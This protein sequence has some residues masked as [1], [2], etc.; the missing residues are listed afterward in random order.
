[1][2]VN[3]LPRKI[4]CRILFTVCFL[5]FFLITGSAAAQGL[6][7][8]QRFDTIKSY[9]P[10]RAGEAYPAAA[11]LRLDAVSMDV[12]SMV[13]KADYLLGIAS[14]Y[15]S[16]FLLAEKHFREAVNSSY[17]AVNAEFREKCWNNL[18]IAYDKENRLS[19]SRDAYYQSLKILE[20]RR[21]SGSMMETYI[22]I[23]KLEGRYENYPK[24]IT[25]L[26]EVL[27]Y[28]IRV[29]DTLNIALCNLNLSGIFLEV[30][31]RKNFEYHINE[32][33]K[34]YEYTN[35]EF[36]IV[37]S[38]L[39]KAEGFSQM[40]A[41]AESEKVINIGLQRC[42]NLPFEDIKLIFKV[43]SA[44]NKVRLGTGLDEAERVLNEMEQSVVLFGAEA[45]TIKIL[46]EKAVLYAR[47]GRFDE[48]M[49]AFSEVVYK[50]KAENQS[51]SKRM[52]EE[53]QAIYDNE[54]LRE[55]QE[56]LK[57]RVSEKQLWIYILISVLLI[58]LTAGIVIYR[59]F[60]R[61]K[62]RTRALFYL[63]RELSKSKPVA[64]EPEPEKYAWDENNGDEEDARLV[65]L[66][67][68]ILNKME[69]D[70]PYLD[71]GFNLTALCESL[72]RSERYVSLAINKIGKTSFNRL[73]VRYRINEARRLIA[74]YGASVMLNDIAD[75]SGFSNRISF[76]R[77][78]KNETGLSPTEYL[79][80]SLQADETE[81]ADS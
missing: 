8:M 46:E 22:N 30:K 69:Q 68:M 63:N 17:A 10:A 20:S 4:R 9:L 29:K 77:N 41:Y 72:N 66:Y 34:L 6:S 36:G 24:A 70:R 35:Y 81:D 37:S 45:Y 13:A 2:Q 79:T 51:S 18:G 12:D 49:E 73:V 78:F 76:Y 74:L 7:L 42:A 16:K 55:E 48:F 71:S 28:F 11:R 40:E 5:I 43:L 50:L 47:A 32:A 31:D 80:M 3:F 58:I 33:L 64:N 61:L 39:H 53:V 65:N 60:I 59:L 75:Q 27:N 25:G 15:E 52:Y 44:T 1:M 23:Y 62:N 54:K 21:D 56:I 14:L 38:L 26:K 67:E 19:E 57:D